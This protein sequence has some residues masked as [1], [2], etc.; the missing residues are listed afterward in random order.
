MFPKTASLALAALLCLAAGCATLY[1]L[2]PPRV[3]V[4]SVT[5]VDFTLLEQKFLV[6]V[7]V[8]NPNDVDLEVKG[9]TFDLDLNGKSFATGV[10]GQ[11]V[12]IPRFGSDL[13]EVEMVSGIAG[14]VRQF[15]GM[16][17]G[18][19]PARFTWRLK[20]KL[21]LAQPVPASIGFDESGE[22]EIAAL[23]R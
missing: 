9:M 10:S 4:S 13:V 12:T 19:A 8:Q 22:I 3:N 21:H 15:A 17:G 2:D 5:P 18:A 14:V 1:G 11:A 7:R 23:A 20:G 16:A 6:K